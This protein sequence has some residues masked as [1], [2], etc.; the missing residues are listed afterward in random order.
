M[1]DREAQ[2]AWVD[3]VLRVSVPAASGTSGGARN[4]ISLVRLGTARLAW[5][6]VRAKALADIAIVRAAVAEAFADDTE[7]QQALTTALARIGDLAGR[8]DSALEDELDAVLNA[9]PSD[10]AGRVDKALVVLAR[11][12]DF[13]DADPLMA[14]IDGNEITP[15]IGI[16]APMRQA[17]ADVGAALG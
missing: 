1:A 17:L 16:A 15:Q 14:S 3:R 9:A 8:F 2:N 13:L 11:F 5:G 10:R 4:G 12:R 7:Q 6:N